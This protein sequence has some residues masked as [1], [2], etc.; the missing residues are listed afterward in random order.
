MSKA[1]R[2][3][4]I[5]FSTTYMIVAVLLCALWMRSHWRYEQLGTQTARD[6]A[7]VPTVVESWRGRLWFVWPEH[8]VSATKWFY[9]SKPPAIYFGVTD[10][11]QVWRPKDTLGFTM[12][13]PPELPFGGGSFGVSVPHW[14]PVVVFIALAA[15]PWLRWSKRFSLRTLLIAMTLVA[16]VL[17]L[18][19]WLTRTPA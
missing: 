18:V 9:T 5:A 16:V 19:V 6:G 11:S 1:L 10:L 4:R 3:L 12:R 8:G 13:Y 15:A 2:Y 14:F 17:G 7:A